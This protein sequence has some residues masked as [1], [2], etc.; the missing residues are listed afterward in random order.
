AC[1]LF[2]L[3]S[4]YMILPYLQAPV[5]FLDSLTR[6]NMSI[7]IVMLGAFLVLPPAFIFR[8]NKDIVVASYLAGANMNNGNSQFKGAIGRSM[9]VE[10]R[11]Y[12]LTSIFSEKV[13]SMV[14]G[15]VCIGLS[16]VM[17]YMAAT[18]PGWGFLPHLPFAPVGPGLDLA[19]KGIAL[20]IF[21][22]GAPILGGLLGGFDRI[23]TARMQGRVGPPI[24]QPFFDVMKLLQKRTVV[25]N[26][27][28]AYYVAC[29]FLFIVLT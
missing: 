9:G 13:I 3:V 17:F 26:H 11:N 15:A 10:M 5:V 28:Q 21:L 4:S 1:A 6:G 27:A 24:L 14:G 18:N 7:M 19:H 8:P 22:I 23:V 25:V 20:A 29:F 2:P 16:L 12:Y